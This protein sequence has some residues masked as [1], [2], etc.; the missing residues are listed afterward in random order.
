MSRHDLA[1]R[2]GFDASHLYRIEVG[3]RRPS[4]EL[5]LK[6]AQVLHLDEDAMSDWLVSAGYA[7]MPFVTTLRPGAIRTRGGAR[8]SSGA[9]ARPLDD[10]STPWAR[11]EAIGFQETRLRRVLRAAES[12]S[13]ADRTEVARLL[14][15]TFARLA[16]TLEARV[17]TAVVPAAGGQH[18]LVGA[19][20]MQRLLLRVIDEA[21]EAGVS[22][23]V[24][25][26]APGMED[27]LYTPLKEALDLAVVP[28][29]AL[30]H[31]TQPAPIG[32]GDAILQAEKLTGGE[33]FAVLLPDD[34]VRGRVT[35]TPR[36]R[37]LQAMM[38]VLAQL[39]PCHLVAVTP[40]PKSKMASHGVVRVVAKDA[41][42]RTFQVKQLA[43]KPGTSHPIARDPRALGIVGRYVLQPEI[44]G[45]LHRLSRTNLRPIHLT[46]AIEDL[47]QQGRP[48]YAVE[49]DAN[50]HDLGDALERPD[51]LFG[52]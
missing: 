10:A 33:P 4:R 46:D 12:A 21:A 32:L 9:L 51:D 20:V 27:A 45:A 13:E 31:C 5:A 17:R 26:L 18:R 14:S 48:V 35:R 38:R 52:N 30:H 47:R 1:G 43:E 25:V 8:R 29:L 11:L 40:I 16:E 22:R 2:A 23:I 50:R 6:L 39:E 7:P 15:S 37:P 49:I 24:L 3:E 41:A 44:M 28:A 19:H 34:V 42:P 36:A